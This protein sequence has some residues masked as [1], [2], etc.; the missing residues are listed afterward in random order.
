MDCKKLWKILKEIGVSDPLTCLL[1][2]LYEGQETVTVRP[3]CGTMDCFKSGKGEQYT[4]LYIVA[5]LV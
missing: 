2:N 5:L 1:R 4:R 3:G